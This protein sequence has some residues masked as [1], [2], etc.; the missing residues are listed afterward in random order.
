MS[1][2]RTMGT[3]ECA[4]YRVSFVRE[5]RQRS[6]VHAAECN[7]VSVRRASPK[8]L[9]DLAADT[10]A[11]HL[12]PW[13]VDIGKLQSLDAVP[14]L[15]LLPC[16][17]G[18][19]TLYGLDSSTSNCICLPATE[20]EWRTLDQVYRSYRCIRLK[21]YAGTNAE[22]LES[23]VR[24]CDDLSFVYTVDLSNS[25]NVKFK[26]LNTI[27]TRCAHVRHLV[28]QNCH[29]MF[30]NTRALAERY[31]EWHLERVQTLDLFNVHCTDTNFDSIVGLVEGCRSLLRF[32]FGLDFL[33]REG[34]DKQAALVMRLFEALPACT[35]SIDVS[36]RTLTY[37]G[38]E[39]AG[40]PALLRQICAKFAHLVV[41]DVST[42]VPNSHYGQTARQRT[43]HR[44][45]NFSLQ[46]N[47]MNGMLHVDVEGLLGAIPTT[48]ET[49]DISGHVLYNVCDDV[50]IGEVLA[51]KRLSYLG[52]IYCV[53]RGQPDMGPFL[54]S[55][56]KIY[57]SV[58]TRFASA[59]P[60]DDHFY[61][62][63][64]A[65]SN[66]MTN[67][68][69]SVYL[70][71]RDPFVGH[72][73]VQLVPTWKRGFVES[74]G[75]RSYLFAVVKRLLFEKPDY[76]TAI[77]KQ[78][79]LTIPLRLN[80]VMGSF[81]QLHARPHMVRVMFYLLEAQINHGRPRSPGSTAVKNFM[82][83]NVLVRENILPPTHRTDTSLCE[84]VDVFIWLSY[85]YL[86]RHQA[87]HRLDWWSPKREH[88]RMHAAYFV[89]LWDHIMDYVMRTRPPN[90]PVVEHTAFVHTYISLIFDKPNN[91]LCA[92]HPFFNAPE[93][94]VK[95]GRRGDMHPMAVVQSAPLM[96]CT[97]RDVAV[98][99]DLFCNMMYTLYFQNCVATVIQHLHTFLAHGPL[100]DRPDRGA[101]QIMAFV[102]R[103]RVQL[104]QMLQPQMSPATV[105]PIMKQD[106]ARS[107]IELVKVVK[108]DVAVVANLIELVRITGG[109]DVLCLDNPGHNANV[110]GINPFFFNPTHNFSVES[111]KLMFERYMPEDTKEKR[112]VCSLLRQLFVYWV[113]LLLLMYD[114]RFYNMSHRK[115]VDS[116]KEAHGILSN[117]YVME[118]YKMT[119]IDTLILNGWP[120]CQCPIV[121]DDLDKLL[122]VV[123]PPQP[124]NATSPRCIRSEICKLLRVCV[125]TGRS[126]DL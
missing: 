104:Y 25:Q 107:L 76:I 89:P 12:Q 55:L 75:Y 60:S 123:C 59:A 124:P 120:Q 39:H 9:N 67:R 80:K 126:G 32:C 26:V 23:Y 52:L 111:I 113:V 74:S 82:D 68:L 34:A 5:L 48:L 115:I 88:E 92:I 93:L 54:H 87:V 29:S 100:N 2:H 112:Y 19:L 118:R 14:T 28:L 65:K 73:T 72:R 4:E 125:V 6:T 108:Q 57:V 58:M 49:L 47:T 90:S 66:T 22:A 62:R 63:R 114:T 43:V 109:V 94:I 85:E 35:K 56:K 7:A 106:A 8:Q 103:N 116:L 79:F 78:F 81:P 101:N 21:N 36:G 40:R 17:D 1:T 13:Q 20:Q 16:L 53:L 91:R 83:L 105:K 11:H 15:N 77:H 96:F 102:K 51:G 70:L 44:D 41:L 27:M 18:P 45:E 42:Y 64:L 84:A 10:F 97:E 86:H 61:Y 31:P 121:K 71:E 95:W 38:D 110:S 50:R 122:R 117:V 24:S 69:Y 98:P 119:T 3:L 99:M 46:R 37:A 33:V 30:L